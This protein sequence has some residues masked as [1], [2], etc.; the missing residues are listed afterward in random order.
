[1]GFRS[2]VS[3]FTRWQL[4]AVGQAIRGHRVPMEGID[5]A[6]TVTALTA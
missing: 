5:L 2:L 3:Y 6:M 1:M 4:L